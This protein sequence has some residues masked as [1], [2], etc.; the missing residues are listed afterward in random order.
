M[1]ANSDP[2]VDTT[3]PPSRERLTPLGGGAVA[4]ESLDGTE[5]YV[6]WPTVTITKVANTHLDD[7]ESFGKDIAEP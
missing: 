2:P 1:S 3:H 6:R 4:V 7:L 5:P